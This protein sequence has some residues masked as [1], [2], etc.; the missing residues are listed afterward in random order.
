MRFSASLNFSL[1]GAF[2]ILRFGLDVIALEDRHALANLR[3]LQQLG[4]EAIVKVGGVVGNLVGQIDELRLQ[5]RPQIEQVF[6]QLG[7]LGG[8]VIVRVL[9][10]AL[11]DFEGQV[12]AAKL[13]VAQLHLLDRAQRLQ[14]VVEELAMLAHQQVERA[15]A[16]VPERRMPDVVHQRQRLG[17]VDIQVELRC[18]GARDLRD[19]DGVRQASAKVVGVAAG[20]DLRL[21][22]QPAEGARVDDAVA[23]TLKCIAIGMR[24]LG[25]AASARFLHANGI[26]CEHRRSLAA[27]SKP[28]QPGGSRVARVV[29]GSRRS[30]NGALSPAKQ[31]GSMRRNVLPMTQKTSQAGE[32]GVRHGSLGG[33]SV[34]QLAVRVWTAANNDDVFGRSA[35]LAYYFFRALFPPLICLT[36]LIG[37]LAGSGTQPARQPFDATLQPALPPVRVSA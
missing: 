33:L 20:E 10:D 29:A 6:G 1:S 26:R 11:A 32:D 27:A 8:A 3:Q 4:L 30:V 17:Q 15:L 36:A 22:F 12:Q 37:M 14:V 16:G 23:V 7:M 9:D 5:R 18:D 25:I 24:R 13:R 34:G 19:L 28:C 2:G 21:V 31:G 35:Q